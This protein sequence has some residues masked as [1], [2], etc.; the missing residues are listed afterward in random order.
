[1]FAAA[2]ALGVTAAGLAAAQQDTDIEG[3]GLFEPD[4][5]QREAVPT[6]S[7]L[8]AMLDKARSNEDLA[9]RH[10]MF[11]AAV[12]AFDRLSLADAAALRGF[13]GK[14]F[15]E[16]VTSSYLT[17]AD[18]LAAGSKEQEHVLSQARDLLPRI[19]DAERQANF[20]ITLARIEMAAG[21]AVDGMAAIR[22]AS[23]L[24][25]ALPEGAV[26]DRV[27]VALVRLSLPLASIDIGMKFG[28]SIAIDEPQLA[29]GAM[30]AVA[31]AEIASG[32]AGRQVFELA[33]R[34]G[35]ERDAGLSAFALAQL[36]GGNLR[37]ALI[38]A[39]A[40]DD[41]RSAER[42]AALSRLLQRQ[43]ERGARPEDILAPFAISDGMMREAALV[44]FSDFAIE[45]GRL[46]VARGVVKHLTVPLERYRALAGI[47]TRL[48]RESYTLAWAS[49]WDDAARAA[50]SVAAVRDR[51]L[52]LSQL[53]VQAADAGDV[54][55]AERMLAAVGTAPDGEAVSQGLVRAAIRAGDLDGALARFGRLEVAP[56]R[57]AVA[58]ELYAALLSRGRGDQAAQVLPAADTPADR[59]TV[60]LADADFYGRNPA[61]P[62]FDAARSAASLEQARGEL[63]RIADPLRRDQQVAAVAKAHVQRADTTGVEAA[64]EFATPDGR[65]G[66]SPLRVG[67][68]ARAHGAAAA[69][70][71]LEGL[72]RTVRDGGLAEISTALSDR[73]DPIAA[74][75]AAR[76]IGSDHVRRRALRRVAEQQAR[77]QRLRGSDRAAASP[78]PA[79]P[80]GT[81]LSITSDEFLLKAVS[82][83][84]PR[85]LPDVL[86][87]AK[88]TGED[89]RRMVPPA[90]PG[91]ARLVP[92]GFSNFDEKFSYIRYLNNVDFNGGEEEI[93]A[94]GQGTLFPHFILV[95]S[96]VYDLPTLK[97]ELATADAAIQPITNNGRVYQ[98]NVPLLIGSDATLVITSS[99]VEELRLNTPAHAYIVNSGKLFLVDTRL[100][101]W[102]PATA[103]PTPRTKRVWNEFSPFYTAWSGSETYMAD[104]H[105]NG[106]GY[107]NGKSYGISISNGPINVLK[108]TLNSVPRP[109]GVIVDST[110]TDMYYAFYSYEADDFKLV[111]NEYNNNEVYGIDPHDRSNRLTIAYNTATGTRGKHG[112]ITSREVK[113]SVIMGNISADNHG[114]GFMLDRTSDENIVAFNLGFRNGADGLTVYES[115][116]NLIYRNTFLQ[117]GRDGVKL[118]NSWNLLV[119]QNQIEENHGFGINLYASRLEDTPEAAH[120]DFK[121]DPYSRYANVTALRNVINANGKSALRSVET[122]ALILAGNRMSA[123]PKGLFRQSD[124][125]RIGPSLLSLAGTGAA[126][127]DTCQPARPETKCRFLEEGYFGDDIIGALDQETAGSQCPKAIN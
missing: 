106:M 23:G 6:L 38:A 9:A 52:A 20:Y 46:A 27:R 25:V 54:E 13:D 1:M 50:A 75:D 85:D 28:W 11:V 37:R 125:Q 116:C 51:V 39:L 21:D 66:M 65:I 97:A 113:D 102:D 108:A 63:A 117:N 121:L 79:A 80:K 16:E 78:P 62:D 77:A 100:T 94:Q 43:I 5:E 49:T 86:S 45:R 112:I 3:A 4:T 69:F 111:G 10:D 105:V 24:V 56:G 2:I 44:R 17:Y 15:L 36:S 81:A 61:A 95:E 14:G 93:L 64:L 34:D 126:L 90:S 35:V 73:Q 59:V 53:G 92:T 71:L 119:S 60:L 32:R 74:Y 122:G 88:V 124:F 109:K 84:E 123:D 70:A 89:V 107:A 7:D 67:A 40:I 127:R 68:T 83:K 96:G 8:Q 91:I 42:D 76:M 41:Q 30:R 82:L 114:S 55:R 110:F 98:L 33:A 101:S 19:R 26:R 104:A 18:T 31:M 48:F 57:G 120:R 72:P 22:K 115:S 58:G 99:D 47:A 103:A 29:R 87:A 118:R 12:Q